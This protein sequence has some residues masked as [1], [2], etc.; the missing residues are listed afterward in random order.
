MAA[1]IAATMKLDRISGQLGMGVRAGRIFVVLAV[2]IQMGAALPAF[3]APTSRP[4]GVEMKV[5]PSKLDAFAVQTGNIEVRYADHRS[6]ILTK[7]G[8]CYQPRISSKGDVGWI[9]LDKSKVD[10]KRQMLLG[11][12]ELVIQTSDGGRVSFSPNS[13]ARFIEDWKFAKGGSE[14]VLRSRGF[15]GPSF[16]VRYNLSTKR[17]LGEITAYRSMKELPSWAKAIAD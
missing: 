15:H 8:W 10:W 4:V 7:D 17:K 2:V 14:V 13:E 6:E 11:K 12:T 9:H 5:V 16:Y 1:M 3:S